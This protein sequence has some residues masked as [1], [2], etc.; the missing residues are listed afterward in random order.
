MKRS[1]R[2]IT[3]A[4]ILSAAPWLCSR[5]AEAGK[6]LP[7]PYCTEGGPCTND[8]DCG[9]DQWLQQPA[10]VCGFYGTCFCR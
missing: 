8:L 4:G 3:L 9:W 1:L 5:D 6:T 7:P 2:L 10:G